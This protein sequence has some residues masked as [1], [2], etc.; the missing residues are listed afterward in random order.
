MRTRRSPFFWHFTKFTTAAIASGIAIA[1]SSAHAAPPGGIDPSLFEHAPALKLASLTPGAPSDPT[2][3]PDTQPNATDAPSIESR[4]AKPRS[5]RA[6]FLLDI[7][8]GGGTSTWSGDPVG[9]TSLKLGT[10]FGEMAGFY[11]RGSLGY[12][13]VEQRVLLGLALGG[14]FWI[15]TPS[16]RPYIRAG[17]LH[18]HEEPIDTIDNVGEA[19][20]GVGSGIRHRS[21]LEGALGLEFPFYKGKRNS[22]AGTV[23]V[24]T[25]Y[26]F[27]DRGPRLYVLGALGIGIHFDL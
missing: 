15:P 25:P 12:A 24:A 4:P 7:A 26:L 11:F 23:E 2:L 1:A 14:Q 21:G 20:L 8:Y 22:V 6:E 17:F 3:P 16:V 27:D 5:R 10:R 19:M 13:G 18:F 9:L